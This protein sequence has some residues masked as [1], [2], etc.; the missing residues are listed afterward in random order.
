[1]SRAEARRRLRAG[2][3]LFVLV[4]VALALLGLAGYGIG[5]V[6]LTTT[7]GPTAYLFFRTSSSRPPLAQM[8]EAAVAHGCAVA[9]AL[10]ALTVFGVWN[11]PAVPVLQHET[12][13]QIWAQA[14]ATGLT[15]L[16]LELCNVHHAPAAAT[17]LLITSGITRPGEP[18]YGL[19][20]SLAALIVA[21]PLLARTILPQDASAEEA[22]RQA[23]GSRSTDDQE[24]GGQETGPSRPG[25]EQG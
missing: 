1:M 3:R 23:A 13:R 21:G 19:L 9:S 10:F 7:L 12:L 16:L 14:V 11:R 22:A 2:L 18:L 15:L 4:G 20:I 6:L 25:D 5:W 8:R 17:A 24:T